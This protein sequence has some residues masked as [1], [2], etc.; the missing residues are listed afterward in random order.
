M[1]AD[2]ATRLKRRSGNGVPGRR[3]PP[4]IVNPKVPPEKVAV[5]KG[6]EKSSCVGVRPA[7]TRKKTDNTGV[8]TSS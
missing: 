7:E 6:S 4:D 3:V 8:R 5:E 2:A 1:L